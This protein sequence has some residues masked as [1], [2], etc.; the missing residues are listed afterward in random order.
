MNMSEIESI[1]SRIPIGM[2][3]ELNQLQRDRLVAN[4]K[5]ERSEYIAQAIRKLAGALKALATQA[6][7]EAGYDV[8]AVRLPQ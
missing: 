3:L 7:S 5:R 2:Q 1:E 8:G 6:R 4:A